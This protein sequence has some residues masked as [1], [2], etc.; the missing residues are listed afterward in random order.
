V[1]CD[2]ASGRQ[3]VDARHADVH[4]H[5]VRHE[6]G[7]QANGLLAV[8]GLADH[9]DVF[10]GIEQGPESRPHQGLVVGEKDPDHR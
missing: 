4:E 10:L 8:A 6:L 9:L 2:L 5:D 1:R 7:S 3:A